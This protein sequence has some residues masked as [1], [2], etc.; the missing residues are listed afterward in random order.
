MSYS[1]YELH[2][3]ENI[4]PII[5]HE[6]SVENGYAS[7]PAHWH[8]SLELLFVTRG[9]TEFI[10][11]GNSHFASDGDLI[12]IPSN[13]IHSSKSLDGNS[14]HYTLI[15]DYDYCIIH[16]FDL[17]NSFFDIPVRDSF[18]NHTISQIATTFLENGEYMRAKVM[19]NVLS[20]LL[21]IYSN[22]KISS[23]KTLPERQFMI[24]KEALNFIEDNY[25]KN[26]S[27]ADICK[28][29]GISSSYFGHIFKDLTSHSPIRYL[30]YVRCKKAKELLK[31]N[32]YSIN[33]ICYLC[34]FNN[35]SYFIKTY[36]HFYNKSPS[37]FRKDLI[38]EKSHKNIMPENSGR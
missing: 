17:S 16:G 33:Q 28:S 26:I 2:T 14:K 19:K 7:F 27:T 25:Q 8:K 9:K 35:I 31:N 3:N 4:L 20:L 5:F 18:I 32:T 10:I 38:S 29:I 23:D 15:V 24:I 22:Y 12:I 1:H 11:D 36:K 13:S 37:E 21:H 30:N 34:G 6:D